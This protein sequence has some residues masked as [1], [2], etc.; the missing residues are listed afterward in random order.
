MASAPFAP[1]AI[2]DGTSHDVVVPGGR[3]PRTIDGWILLEENGYSLRMLSRESHGDFIVS[4]RDP[5]GK[6]VASATADSPSEAA[7]EAVNSAL[8]LITNPTAKA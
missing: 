8:D 2:K 5:M 1:A 4:I 7:Q 6:L 3:T